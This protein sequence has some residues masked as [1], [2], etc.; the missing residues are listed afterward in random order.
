MRQLFYLLVI[1]FISKDV[2]MLP[3][4]LYERKIPSR[5][6]FVNMWLRLGTEQ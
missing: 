1:K 2:P 4:K 3:I 5:Q 6:N